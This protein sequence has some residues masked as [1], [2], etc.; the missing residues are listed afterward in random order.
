MERPCP[1]FQSVAFPRFLIPLDLSN[2]TKVLYALL[3]DRA[4]ISRKKGFIEADGTIRLYFTVEAAKAKLHRSRQ[5]ATRAFH[6]L[7]SCGLIFRR[8]QGL[9]RPAVITLNLPA[10]ERRGA[11]D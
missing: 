10:G 8:K 6:E 5:V 11:N 3:W 4:G 2:G 1:V 9:G 7:E